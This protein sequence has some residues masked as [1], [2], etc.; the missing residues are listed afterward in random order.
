MRYQIF[1]PYFVS[2]Y[3]NTQPEHVLSLAAERLAILGNL[4]C[5]ILIH[6]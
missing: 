3:L 5:I 4:L 2:Y 6:F 1:L